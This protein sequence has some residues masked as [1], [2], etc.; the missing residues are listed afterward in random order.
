[1]KAIAILMLL[2]FLALLSVLAAGSLT[3][4]QADGK[5]PIDTWATLAVLAALGIAGIVAVIRS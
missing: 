1:M 3:G 2:G 5:F 4:P